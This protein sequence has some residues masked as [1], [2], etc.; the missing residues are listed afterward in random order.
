MHTVL[1]LCLAETEPKSESPCLLREYVD[2]TIPSIV[3]QE[4]VARWHYPAALVLCDM[5]WTV[6]ADV[7]IRKFITKA[8]CKALGSPEPGV[9]VSCCIMRKFEPVLLYVLHRALI[10]SLLAQLSVI[11]LFNLW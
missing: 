11:L 9:V 2:R 6:H 10:V 1:R 5:H 7:I 4:H 3:R 8:T